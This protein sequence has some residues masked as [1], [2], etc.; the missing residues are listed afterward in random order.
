[1]TERLRKKYEEWADDTDDINGP[2]FWT[3][4]TESEAVMIAL[5][6]GLLGW[7]PFEIRKYWRHMNG[8]GY[9]GDRSLKRII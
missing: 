8:L 3:H 9:K 2:F 4:F 7:P 1:M 5:D 6:K